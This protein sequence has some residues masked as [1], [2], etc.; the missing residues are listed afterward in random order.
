M[1]R[2]GRKALPM[3]PKSSIV[4]SETLS[5]KAHVSFVETKV[6]S[7][8]IEK[9]IGDESLAALQVELARN[10]ETGPVIEG[11]G[12]LRKARWALK[13]RG[14]SGGIRVIYLYLRIRNVIY[15]VYAFSKDESD[16]LTPD[17]KKQLKAIVE[18]IKQ[19]YKK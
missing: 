4:H 11:T 6:F 15:L 14:K 18:A 3:T 5:M 1:T 9:L 8:R 16:D 19:E 12:G 10:P 7:K 17:Q 13:G 2:N